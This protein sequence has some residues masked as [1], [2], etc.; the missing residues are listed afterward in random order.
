MTGGVRVAVMPDS[1]GGTLDAVQAAAAIGAGWHAGRPDDVVVLAPQSDGGPGF[2]DVL[3]TAFGGEVRTQTVTGPLGEPVRASWLLHDG[4]AYLEAAQAC[5]LHLLEQPPT[6]S[7]AVAATSAGV[8]D[9]LSAA[10]LAGCRTI[11]VG[12]GG[13]AVSDGGRGASDRL[14][15]CAAARRLLSDVELIV[16]TDV[17]NPLLGPAGAVPVFGPQ[18]GADE[19]TVALLEKRMIGW[20]AQLEADCGVAVADTP[21]AGA[22]GGLGAVLLAWGGRR[23]SGSEFVAEQTGRRAKIAAAD[24]VITGEGRLDSQ[25]LRGKVVAVV[26]AEAYRAGVPVIVLAGQSTLPVQVVPNVGEVHSLAHHTGSIEEAVANAGPRL[27]DLAA[28]VA[29]RWDPATVATV[30]L[31]ADPVE[32]NAEESSAVGE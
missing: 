13:S 31:A 8:G 32:E 4:V 12:L 27:T 26:A 1:F 19:S 22:A 11:V 14:G 6:P 24:V 30:E 23:V 29:A 16:A 20:A 18:K 2:I 5:G 25:T 9:L 28:E 17:D 21:G 3:A 10:L 7:T 15:G